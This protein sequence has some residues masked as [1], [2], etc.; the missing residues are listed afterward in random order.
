MITSQQA[1]ERPRRSKQVGGAQMGM[2]ADHR[3]GRHLYEGNFLAFSFRN[4][5][6]KECLFT[7]VKLHD[8]VR[9]S[10]I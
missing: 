10:A 6:C 2:T 4:R 5:E 8:G 3:E 9:K 7:L 1:R